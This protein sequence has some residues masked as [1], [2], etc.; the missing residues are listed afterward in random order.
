MPLGFVKAIKTKA[1]KPR[2]GSQDVLQIASSVVS[3]TKELT[4][5][6]FFPPA[7]AAVSIVLLMLE[8]IQVR[9]T[10]SIVGS[11]AS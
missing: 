6:S 8:T 11:T 10:I 4:T 7:T 5:L 3:L 9:K 1:P 2:V